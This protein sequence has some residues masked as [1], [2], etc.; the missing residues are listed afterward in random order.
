MTS[1]VD[2]CLPVLRFPAR[3]IRWNCR[4][5]RAIPLGRAPQWRTIGSKFYMRIDPHDVADRAFYLGT[6][7]PHLVQLIRNLVRP[8]DVCL[9][10]GA[11]KGFM[12]LH[13]AGAAGPGGRVISFEPDPRA[14]DALRA[15]AQRNALVQVSVYP[16]ALGDREAECEFALSRQIGW[17]SRFPN[18]LAR[19]TV[20]ST[21]SVRTRRL[22]DVIAELGIRPAADRLSLIKVD[23]EGSELL[24]LQGALETLR[25][26]RPTIHIEINREALAAGGFTPDSVEGLLRSFDYDLFT[27]RFRRAGAW[28]R[29]RL[30]LCPV[31]SL[32]SGMGLCEDVLAVHPS[33]ASTL[34][35]RLYS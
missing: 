27:L 20:F 18:E 10:V 22:D 32:T 2:A 16:C 33:C 15:N 23:A 30:D 7:S 4:Q 3:A 29:R 25:R 14:V 11:Q 6:F 26:F 5:I 8:G 12:T 24:V 13:M 9:D 28:L 19:S 21:I 17:S 34:H 35:G 31:A 1:F